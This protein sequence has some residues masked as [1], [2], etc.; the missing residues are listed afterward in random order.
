MPTCTCTVCTTGIES[1]DRL[2]VNTSRCFNMAHSETVAIGHSMGVPT[3]CAHWKL[4]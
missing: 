2:V 3:I 1:N 4:L